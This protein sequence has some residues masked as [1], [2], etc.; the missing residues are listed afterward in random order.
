[1]RMETSRACESRVVRSQPSISRGPAA[2][3][4][5]E[6]VRRAAA[7]QARSAPALLRLFWVGWGGVLTGTT[8]GADEASSAMS[9]VT[10]RGGMTMVRAG[11]LFVRRAPKGA[12]LLLNEANSWVRLASLAMSALFEREPSTIPMVLGNQL[13]PRTAGCALLARLQ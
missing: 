4:G 1:M 11:V 3:V 13:R 12:T 7:E 2:A 5:R 6:R 10:R 8:Q 9:V